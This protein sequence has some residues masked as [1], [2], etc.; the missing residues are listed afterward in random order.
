MAFESSESSVARAW[1]DR[2]RLCFSLAGTR[3]MDSRI[4]LKSGGALD[5]SD[6]QNMP[7]MICE[8]FTSR[9]A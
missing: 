3:T 6:V 9:D 1:S 8:G 2:D 7:W 5:V 4:V